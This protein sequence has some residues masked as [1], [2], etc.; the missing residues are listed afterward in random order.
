M[1]KRVLLIPNAYKDPELLVS[2]EIADILSAF[3]TEV[4]ADDESAE[5]LSLHG[6]RPLSALGGALELI[7]AVGGDGTV[8]SAA[9]D[10][11]RYGLPLLG[12]NMGRLGFLAE[13]ESN[14]LS[15]LERLYTGEYRV[16]DRMMLE[17]SV[18]IGD[19]REV[20]KCTPLNDAVF[21]HE[22]GDGLSELALFDGD[23]NRI[24]YHAD[25]LILSTP[26]GSTAYS[27]SSGGPIID[28]TVEAICVT[29]VCPHSFFNRSV[30]FGRNAHL[31]VENCSLHGSDVILSL[32][33]TDAARIP[34]GGRVHIARSSR[35]L[36]MLTFDRHATLETLN[37]KM[38]MADMKYRQS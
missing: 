20:M 24:D 11:V 3:G 5:A 17:V 13:L 21:S 35:P 9:Q 6:V 29:P 7:I 16:T 14:A 25:G 22:R 10:A 15:R 32:D 2:G 30:V 27:L 18:E 36:R 33:G 12:V 8:L 28:D 31:T 19:K 23:G 38:Q 1:M 34:V 37:R 4:Y 26:S